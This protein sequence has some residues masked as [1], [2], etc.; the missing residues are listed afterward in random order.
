MINDIIKKLTTDDVE[1]YLI[2]TRQELFNLSCMIDNSLDENEIKELDKMYVEI[3][4][5]IKTY[6]DIMTYHQ[7]LNLNNYMKS[8][9]YRLINVFYCIPFKKENIK[10][11][12]EQ[13]IYEWSEDD[14]DEQTINSLNTMKQLKN[15]IKE[16]MGNDWIIYDNNFITC[17]TVKF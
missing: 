6:Q 12:K 15:F 9:G 1:D 5:R 13:M 7:V 3:S 4:D 14:K 8:K 10:D 11:I 16:H 2:K 17:L